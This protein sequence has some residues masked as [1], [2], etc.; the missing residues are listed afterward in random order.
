[1]SEIQGAFGLLD[2][3][4]V[5]SP[6]Q[7]RPVK[8]KGGHAGKKGD[9]LKGR[10]RPG[11]K[12]DGTV[13]ASKKTVGTPSYDGRRSNQQQNMPRWR[14]N[15]VEE[16]WRHKRMEFDGYK[17]EARIRWTAGSY[18][19]AIDMYGKVSMVCG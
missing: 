16:E 13:A 18:D 7:N 5:P 11:A 3:A 6:V 1:M 10:T 9:L 19:Q 8:L 15:T 2:M 17:A 14:L 4:N 12:D